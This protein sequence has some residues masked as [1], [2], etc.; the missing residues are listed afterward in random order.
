MTNTE[1]VLDK[2]LL[3]ILT[4]AHLNDYNLINEYNTV[5]VFD[6]I[7][8]LYLLEDADADDAEGFDEDI[9]FF[10]TGDSA[11]SFFDLYRVW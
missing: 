7:S 8:D 5:Y 2:S 6:Y 11:S 9:A 10:A 3:G 1:D 4:Y